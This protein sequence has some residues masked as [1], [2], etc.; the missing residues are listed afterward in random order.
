MADERWSECSLAN[1]G[2]DTFLDRSSWWPGSDWRLHSTDEHTSLDF[3]PT[4]APKKQP[5]PGGR[6]RSRVQPSAAVY[7]VGRSSWVNPVVLMSRKSGVRGGNS[8]GVRN[9]VSKL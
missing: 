5:A 1:D 3:R 8:E 2:Y 7:C 9:S 4:C 6:G